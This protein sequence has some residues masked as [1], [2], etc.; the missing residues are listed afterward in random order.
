ML[1]DYNMVL[2]NAEKFIYKNVKKKPVIKGSLDI[3][4][5]TKP[6]SLPCGRIV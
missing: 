3:F 4:F 5:K 6:K 2:R 1:A